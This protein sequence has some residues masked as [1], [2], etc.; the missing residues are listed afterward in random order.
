LPI[1]PPERVVKNRWTRTGGAYLFADP[2][3]VSH[4]RE[5]LAPC[6][7]LRIGIAWQGSQRYARDRFRSI[8]LAQFAPLAAITGVR[9]MS[10]QK[11][12]GARQ[13]AQLSDRFPVD[14]LAAELDE[15]AGGFVDTAAVITSLDLVISSDT[16]VAHLAGGLGV[17]VW[18][19]LS[20]IPDW[21]WLLSRDDSPWYP[22]MRLF[23]QS[24][25]GDW[26]GVFEAMAEALATRTASE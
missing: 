17:P 20:E 22:T 4:W 11:G 7:G 15:A 6:D 19:A 10:L 3:R 25:R 2:E 24:N 18:V 21:R 5:R 13:V 26:R 16:A 12:P 9:L 1:P 8:P 14:D 23:R